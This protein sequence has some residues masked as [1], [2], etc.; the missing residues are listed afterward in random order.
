[1]GPTAPHA[2]SFSNF[3]PGGFAHPPG[4][5]VDILLMTDLDIFLTDSKYYLDL[6]CMAIY[7]EDHI[8]LIF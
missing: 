3:G 5:A 6:S 2:P 7:S 4:K 8:F 1:L